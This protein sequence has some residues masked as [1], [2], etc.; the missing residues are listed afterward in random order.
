MKTL[1]S[2]LVV[3]QFNASN[4]IV[5]AGITRYLDRDGYRSTSAGVVADLPPKAQAAFVAVVDAAQKLRAADE[6]ISQVFGELLAPVPDQTHTEQ[7]DYTDPE[8][9]ETRQQTVTIVDTYRQHIG[10]AITLEK[11]DNPG[12]RT[13]SVQTEGLSQQARTA[14]LAL[15][16]LL[17]L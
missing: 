14:V 5:G 12:Q 8:T 10:L 9:G 6:R 17:S 11:L 13:V 3:P 7:Q 15:W 4:Q 16:R 1:N 2:L